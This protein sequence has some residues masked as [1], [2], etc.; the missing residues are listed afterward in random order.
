[1]NIAI[2]APSAVPFVVGGAE[3]L[4]WG[5]LDAINQGSPHNA[6]L[7]K[8]PSPER[9]FAELIQSYRKFSQL[10]LDHF[11]LVISTKYPAWMLSHPNHYCY[12]QHRLRGLYDTYHFTGLPTALDAQYAH[13]PLRLRRFVS[14]MLDAAPDRASLEPFFDELEHLRRQSVLAD[15]FAFPGPLSRAI[16]HH[17]DRIGLAPGA[18]RRY[19]AI[20]RNVA[21][22]EHY[23]PAGV[24][25]TV[26]HHPSDLARLDSGPYRNIFTAS[27]LTASKRLDLIIRAF[28]QVDTDRQLRIAGTG[29]AREKLEALAGDD[30]RIRFLGH[31]TDAELSAEYAEALFVPFVPYDEDYGLIT[32]EAMACAKP[33]LTVQDAGGVNELV[34]HGVTG[35]SV[36]ADPDALAAAM[37]ELLRDQDATR[38][39][40]ERARVRVAEIRWPQTI[41]VLLAEPPAA[42]LVHGARRPRIVVAVDFPVY[43]PRGG[44]QARVYNLYRALA[45]HA[46]CTLVTLCNEPGHAGRFALRPGLTEVRVAKSDAHRTASTALDHRLQAS[47][48]DIATLLHAAELTP[49]YAEALR[50]ETAD[51]DLLI[52]S[53]PYLYP[54]LEAITVPRLWYE[55]HNVEYDMKRAVLGDTDTAKPYLAAVRDTEASLCA[56]AERVL[57]CAR[58]DAERLAA[59][60]AIDLAKCHLASNGVDTHLTPYIGQAERTE[61]RRRLGLRRP[62]LL[63]IGSWHQP[64]IEAVELLRGL[65]R[66]LT[67]CDLLVVGSVCAHPVMADPPA[68]LHALGQLSDAELEVLLGAV[69]LALNP[70]NSGSGTNLKMLHYAAAGVPL[71]G[72]PFGARGLTLSNGHDLWVAPVANFPHG[73][74]DILATATDSREQRTRRA[75]ATA[76][77]DYDW[78]VIADGLPLFGRRAES[79][80]E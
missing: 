26:L 2:V 58:A 60:Y 42:P 7:I 52:A 39:M 50:A 32:V 36:A 19:L 59:L 51:C 10:R 70:M 11:D 44:G 77:Q 6:E 30:P 22:R 61:R 25:V 13:M 45:R 72:T 73:V 75:R 9:D 62:T 35:L 71:L 49:A 68:N 63:F 29:P 23:F 38:A 43:P 27:R 66:E 18:I 46:D 14:N 1:M 33:I 79:A 24:D 17:L 57:V 53:H 4:W 20:S 56:R 21:Q 37:R 3:K 5:L 64:N 34:E 48:G 40:G 12:L 8:L 15:Q 28:R 55:A 31:I 41:D 67:D 80:G 65:A 78:R 69:D 47:A 74:R 16:V 76:E 54:V